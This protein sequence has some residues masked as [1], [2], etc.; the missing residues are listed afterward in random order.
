MIGAGGDEYAKNKSGDG[1]G[2]NEN[3]LSEVP[4]E[5]GESRHRERQQDRRTDIQMPQ[6]RK[7]VVG[8]NRIK[9]RSQSP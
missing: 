3:R 2:N 8:K 1:V 9:A 6:M 4:R 5:A 7:S